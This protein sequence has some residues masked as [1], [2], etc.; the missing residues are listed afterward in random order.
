MV[1][2][3]KHRE[4]LQRLYESY[5][6]RE[7]VH[8][9]PLEFLY[10]YRDVRDREVVGLI[11][12][13]L[14]YGNVRQILRSVSRVLAAMG[15]SPYGFL[16]DASEAYLFE[17]FRDFRHRFT[18]G[19]DLSTML[20]GVKQACERHGSLQGCFEQGLKGSHETVIPALGAF[21]R[22]LT[23]QAR[24]EPFYL[25]P[26]PERGSACKRLNLFLRWMV[27][28]DR[29]DPGGWEHVSAS[30]L[31]VPL[32]THMHRVALRLGLTSRK[33]ANLQT[34]CEITEAFRAIDP[35]DPVKYD[36]C[37]TRLG[38]HPDLDPECL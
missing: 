19:K 33:Q 12:S 17:T 35:A 11:A 20:M 31:I 23:G 8:P 14:A 16:I 9:D 34:A 28:N 37:I 36:F 26:S 4:R 25:L 15:E 3:T 32:D 22:E 7:F 38:I 21:V 29:V 30:K 1:R 27:R 13:S 24:Q 18:S 5:N 6:R 10:A 2:V